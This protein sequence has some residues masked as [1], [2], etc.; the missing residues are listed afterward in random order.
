MK[1]TLVLTLIVLLT[2]IGFG[3][4]FIVGRVQAADCK[5]VEGGSKEDYQAVIDAC[6]AKVSEL[7]KQRTTLAE[8]IE[9]MDSQIY[10]TELRI[11]ENEVLK[12]R[13]Q[14]EIENLGTRIGELDTT[15]TRVSISATAKIEEMYKRERGNRMLRLLASSSNLPTLIRTAG[16]LKKTQENDRNLLI[17]LQDTKVNFGEQKSL[18]EVKEEEL[19]QLNAQLEA[20][21]ADLGNQQ[22]EKENLLAVTE[23][24]EATYQQ[25]LSNAEAQL[26]SFGR[27]VQ[28][29]GGASLLGNQTVCDDWGCYYSQRDSQ[30]GNNSLNGTGYTLASDGCLVTSMAMVY[31]HLGRRNVTPQTVNSNPSNFA[32]YYPAYLQ[33]TITA[34]GLTTSRVYA[35]IDETLSTGD[36]VVVGVNAYGGTHFVVLISGSNGSYIMHD[37]FIENGHGLSF[38]D[39]YSDIFEIRKVIAQ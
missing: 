27:F 37:P 1:K 15:L 34:D 11:Q 6:S 25:L 23:N 28:S 35:S 13:L 31:T 14:K 30:W 12:A 36:P 8:Q 24:D 39:Y 38:N 3:F 4:H 18:R 29:Q 9:Y 16:Y 33:Y 10:L 32:P 20:Y 22:A 26:A 5:K 21:Q 19:S 17:R 2:L 7:S